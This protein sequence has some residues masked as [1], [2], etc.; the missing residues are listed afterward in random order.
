MLDRGVGKMVMAAQKF[1]SS[2][3]VSNWIIPAWVNM[4]L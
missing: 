2:V 1:S 4:A 3:G